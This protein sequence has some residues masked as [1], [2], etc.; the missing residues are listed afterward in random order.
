VIVLGIETSTA[1]S[2]VAILV[3]GA[4][5]AHEEHEDAR[6][7]GAFVAPAIRRCLDVIRDG[8]GPVAVD[9]VGVGTGPGLYT[10]LRVGMATAAAFAAASDVPVVGI[11]GLDAL[12]FA[13]GVVDATVVTTLDARRGQV[14]WAVHRPAS[15]AASEAGLGSGLGSGAAALTCVD[16]PH[17]GSREQ[18]DA[19]LA[20]LEAAVLEA[21]GSDGPVRVLGEVGGMTVERPDA[22]AT[23]RLAQRALERAAA[24]HTPVAPPTPVYLRDADVRIGWD[25][26]GGRRG[27]A[28]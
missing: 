28:A 6:G 10:G 3:D 16:G 25:E 14:F 20:V 26:R 8:P 24:G 11:G 19:A 22:V 7:H 4:V 23:A 13:S 17:V 15:E 12:A 21:A 27:G 1:R 9:A 18:L 2:S 5:V